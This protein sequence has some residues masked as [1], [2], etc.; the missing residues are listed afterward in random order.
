MKK[1]TP[2]T[3]RQWR[4]LE[5]FWLCAQSLF[6][7]RELRRVENLVCARTRHENEHPE[8]WEGYP[9]DCQ[10]CRSYADV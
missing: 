7:R 2:M 6:S 3:A 8:W 9:C 1:H 4:Q 10:T 5:R